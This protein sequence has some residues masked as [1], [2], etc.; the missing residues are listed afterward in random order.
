MINL[1]NKK[2]KPTSKN[3]II[4]FSNRHVNSWNVVSFLYFLYTEF[5]YNDIF[6]EYH[7]GRCYLYYHRWI[8]RG[9]KLFFEDRN[10][11]QIEELCMSLPSFTGTTSNI[12][13]VDGFRQIVFIEKEVD[14][15][16]C[17]EKES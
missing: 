10:A 12:T 1:F 5:D 8:P 13:H 11:S 7:C 9:V 14:N 3:K 16:E 6:V 4:D 17:K 15:N 2:W